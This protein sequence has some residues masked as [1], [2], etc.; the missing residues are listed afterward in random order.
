[1]TQLG[2]LF[3]NLTLAQSD[4]NS[5]KC[6]ILCP[7]NEKTAIKRCVDGLSG[8]RLSTIIASRQFSSLPEAKIRMLSSH[9]LLG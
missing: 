4:E 1:M 3:V 5:V 9:H 7:L 2:E 6:Y 8:P